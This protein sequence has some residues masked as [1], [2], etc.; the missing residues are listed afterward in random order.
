MAGDAPIAFRLTLI[1]LISKPIETR[2]QNRDMVPRTRGSFCSRCG[3]MSFPAEVANACDPE[4]SKNPKKAMGEYLNVFAWELDTCCSGRVWCEKCPGTYPIITPGIMDILPLVWP[5][6]SCDW[7]LFCNRPHT[8]G[9][10]LGADRANSRHLERD[11]KTKKHISYL[12]IL[13]PIRTS[14]FE[15]SLAS[16]AQW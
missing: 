4:R 11:A 2:L 14:R 15:R 3:K 13:A 7:D 10:V 1:C 16:M 8:A 5:I 9:L 12:R 6:L